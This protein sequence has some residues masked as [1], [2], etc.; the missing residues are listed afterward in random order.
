[1]QQVWI[2]VPF[3]GF[4]CSLVLNGLHPGCKHPLFQMPSEK[5]CLVLKDVK[6]EEAVEYR[7]S[8][9]LS[10]LENL[11]QQ[12][13]NGRRGILTEMQA[14]GSVYRITSVRYKKQRDAVKNN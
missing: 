2:S 10:V 3:L 9:K 8:E 12:T 5:N 14:C 1:M 7:Q 11:S 6:S 13:D 4:F